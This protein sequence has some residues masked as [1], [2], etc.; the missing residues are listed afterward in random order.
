MVCHTD[1]CGSLAQKRKFHDVSDS[2]NSEADDDG[3]DDDDDRRESD[4]EATSDDKSS[5]KDGGSGRDLGSL[6][7]AVDSEVC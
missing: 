3:D 6:F 2:S 5:K 7:D 1:F 4:T